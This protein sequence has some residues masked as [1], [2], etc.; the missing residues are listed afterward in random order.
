MMNYELLFD[1][2]FQPVQQKQ[3]GG[4]NGVADPPGQLQVLFEGD[5][6]QGQGKQ[7]VGFQPQDGAQRLRKPV[8]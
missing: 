7:R 5:Q 4:I 8:D 6:D 2:L 1:D 3:M